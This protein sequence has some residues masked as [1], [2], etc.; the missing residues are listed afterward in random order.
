MELAQCNAYYNMLIK[1]SLCSEGIRHM[2]NLR[3]AVFHFYLGLPTTVHLV[4][5]ESD[6]KLVWP[7]KRHVV[8]QICWGGGG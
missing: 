8:P 2:R 3:I 7:Q 1:F 5:S 4:V 6:F